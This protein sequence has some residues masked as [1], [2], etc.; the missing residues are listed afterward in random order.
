MP[1]SVLPNVSSTPSI[2]LILAVPLRHTKQEIESRYII[3]LIQN[4]LEFNIVLCFAAV[5]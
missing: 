2:I 1:P 3:T 5:E 4:T